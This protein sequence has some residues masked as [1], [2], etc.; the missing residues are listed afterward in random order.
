MT[1]PIKIYFDEHANPYEGYFWSMIQFWLG[2]NVSINAQSL[3]SCW[4]KTS[5]EDCDYLLYSLQPLISS[6]FDPNAPEGLRLSALAKKFNKPLL[7]FYQGDSSEPLPFENAI[8]FRTSFDF[9]HKKSYEHAIPVIVSDPLKHLGLSSIQVRQ[10]KDRASVGFCGNLRDVRLNPSWFRKFT[11]NLG[12]GIIGMP[13][14]YRAFQTVGIHFSRAPGRIARTQAAAALLRSSRVDF[15][16]IERPASIWDG[17][18]CSK[19]LKE[20]RRD[21]WQNLIGNDYA[22][23]LRGNGN[24]SFRF[25][26]AL[27]CGRIPLFI[28]TDS[29][30]PFSDVINYKDY[31]VWVDISEIEH[32]GDILADFH[33]RLTPRA[34]IDRQHACRELWEQY[35]SSQSAP[36]QIAQQLRRSGLLK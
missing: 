11:K 13:R 24:F 10:K 4:E 7:V 9:S 2:E 8:V 26:E 16:L 3:P 17:G 30:L 31:C 6:C 12:Y 15:N 14:L 25:Y 20:M 35:F 1:V 21:F 18:F 33:A 29:P 32:A 23:C 28:N 22:L 27:A 36:K 34:F 5:I 19:T